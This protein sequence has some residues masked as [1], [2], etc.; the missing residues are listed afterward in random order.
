MPEVLEAMAHLNPTNCLERLR[1]AMEAA[2]DR[3]DLRI[4]DAQRL[5]GHW[6][7]ACAHRQPLPADT[8]WS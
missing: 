4:R 7:A 3:G 1:L 6:K 2:I 8:D 5:N